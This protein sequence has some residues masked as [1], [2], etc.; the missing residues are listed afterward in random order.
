LPASPLSLLVVLAV[1][2]GCGSEDSSPA[3][4]TSSLP[5]GARPIGPGPRFHPPLRDGV[6]IADCR[7]G[8][9]GAREGVHLEL[10]GDDLVVL[11]P[12]GLGTRPPRTMFGGRIERARCYGPVVT[13][14]PTGLVLLRPGTRATVG[15][16][17]ALW[18]QPLTAGRA[19]SFRGEVRVYVNG[20]RVAGEAAA[21]P[22]RRHDNI[23]LEVGPY[24]APHA[25][26][27]FPAGY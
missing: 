20:R 14:D 21:I 27:T 11:F 2:T 3:P 8:G 18:G 25:R 16:V 1:L 17:F 24:V 22:L 13:I 6:P 26:Y 10:F 4:P 12:A 23:V 15:D 7:R 19:A 5:A 9:L